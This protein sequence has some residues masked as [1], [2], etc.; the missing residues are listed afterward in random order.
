MHIT[1]LVAAGLIAAA[2]AV[3]STSPRSPRMEHDHVTA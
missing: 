2:L 3:A 1:V